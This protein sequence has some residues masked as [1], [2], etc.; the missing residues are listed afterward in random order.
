MKLTEFTIGDIYIIKPINKDRFGDEAEIIKITDI[1]E[2]TLAFERMRE[3]NIDDVRSFEESGYG[4][5]YDMAS[6]NSNYKIIETVEKH[7][8]EV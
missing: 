8:T 2:A 4:R 7:D 3:Q 5:R 6:F 1:T